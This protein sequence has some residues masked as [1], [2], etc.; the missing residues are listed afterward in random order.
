MVI[1]LRATII[2]WSMLHVHMYIHHLF[3]ECSS[4]QFDNIIEHYTRSTGAVCLAVHQPFKQEC[5]QR[6]QV[7]VRYLLTQHLQYTHVPCSVRCVQD[8]NAH[9]IN[10]TVSNTYVYMRSLLSILLAI[11][12]SL[13]FVYVLVFI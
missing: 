2:Y 13:M 6:P 7:A 12:A 10:T 1:T 3:T 9:V 5:H 4:P 11:Q 8:I